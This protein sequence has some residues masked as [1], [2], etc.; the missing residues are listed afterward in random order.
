MESVLEWRR[1]QYLGKFQLTSVITVLEVDFYASLPET[2]DATNTT[3]KSKK[4]DF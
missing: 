3:N 4:D 1:F 2:I